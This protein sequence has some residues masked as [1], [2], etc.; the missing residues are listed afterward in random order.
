V[1]TE[2]RKRTL[3]GSSYIR[4][5][6]SHATHLA[7]EQRPSWETDS[8]S[9]AHDIPRFYCTY[10]YY[11]VH[12]SITRFPTWARSIHSTNSHR[13][14]TSSTNILLFQ[15][16]SSLHSL[17][18]RFCTHFSSPHACYM[19]RPS[20]ILDLIIILI[21][22]EEHKLWNPSS[23]SFLQPS[24]TSSLFGPNILLSSLFSNTLNLCYSLNV[25]DHIS[26]SYKTTGK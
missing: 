5:T 17:Q 12:K 24:V 14:Y 13:T 11:S 9:A 18:P 6:S 23:C 4:F 19:P 16:V 3:S 25:R 2:V 15:V 8:D 1:F 21:F 22:A 26:H 7:S 20:H 10:V